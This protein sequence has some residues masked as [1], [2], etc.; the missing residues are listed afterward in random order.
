MWVIFMRC[1]ATCFLVEIEANNGEKVIKP[2]V[3]RTPA[4]ARKFIRHELGKETK[5]YTVKKEKRGV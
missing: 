1:G 2:V 3:A 4:E 5:I